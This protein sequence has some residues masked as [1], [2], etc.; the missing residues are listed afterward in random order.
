M[1][2]GVKL[3]YQMMRASQSP[4]VATNNPKKSLDSPLAGGLKQVGTMKNSYSIGEFWEITGLSV[5]ILRFY[6]ESELRS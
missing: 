6:H 1:T 3:L 5:K 4:E 2:T